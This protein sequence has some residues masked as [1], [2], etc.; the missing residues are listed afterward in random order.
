MNRKLQTSSNKY[1][2]QIKVNGIFFYIRN[3][4]GGE[5]EREGQGKAKDDGIIQRRSEDFA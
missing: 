5:W 1:T 4:V 2:V 3:T